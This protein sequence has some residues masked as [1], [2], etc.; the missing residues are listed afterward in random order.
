MYA[1]QAYTV[2]M[3]TSPQPAPEELRAEEQVAAEP[4]PRIDKRVWGGIKRGG[5]AV[6]AFWRD[7]RPGPEAARGAVYG[8]FAAVATSV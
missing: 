6:A 2:E 5:R 8:G 1:V 3:A 4:R 7:I